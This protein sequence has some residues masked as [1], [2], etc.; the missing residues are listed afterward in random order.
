MNVSYHE[1]ME[2]G[3]PDFPLELYGIDMSHPRYVMQLHWHSEL[4]LIRVI[5]G[6]LDITLNGSEFRLEE[7]HSVFIPGGVLHAAQPHSCEYECVVF[8][9]SMLYG[10]ENCKRLVKSQTNRICVYRTD[11]NTDLLFE[12]IKCRQVGDELEI[13]GRIYM[14]V[15]KVV[16]NT[17]AR[18]VPENAKLEKIKPAINM[19][20]EGYESKLV[21]ASLAEACGLS[22][23]YFSRYFKETVGQTPFEYITIYRIEAAC[24]MFLS[25]SMNITEVCFA[26]GFNDLSYFIHTFKRLKG[27]SPRKYIKNLNT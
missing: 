15:S 17:A 6:R 10:N 26:C 20:E 14:L 18:L 22:Q 1:K 5:K 19:I 11:E 2:R 25:S 4:E 9:P 23:N 7:G 3:T 24:E 8:S 12:R 27:V 13:Y 16:K 21:L